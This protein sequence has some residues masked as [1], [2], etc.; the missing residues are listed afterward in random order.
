M[1]TK[2]SAPKFITWVVAI[3]LG[4]IGILGYTGT[5]AGLGNFSFWLVVIAFALLALASL[6]KGL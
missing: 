4:L 5:L 6:L 2:L 1:K 3:V